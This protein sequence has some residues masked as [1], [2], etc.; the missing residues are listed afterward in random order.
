MVQAIQHVATV[1]H[2]NLKNIYV[3]CDFCSIPQKH[4]PS[5]RAAIQS[6]ALYANSCNALIIAAP[7]YKHSDG[8]PVGVESYQKRAWCRA[9]QV[10]ACRPASARALAARPPSRIMRLTRA[11]A[12]PAA[13]RLPPRSS[14]MAS[15]TGRT[16][17][18]L[19]LGTTRSSLLVLLG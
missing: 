10:C 13:G 11:H 17:C 6:L 18:G 12:P 9:E 2:W 15:S 1:N 4:Y 16:T 8:V 14:A 3:W 19:P 5:Q 7:D